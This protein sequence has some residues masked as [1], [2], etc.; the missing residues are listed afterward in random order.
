MIAV[1]AGKADG[2]ETSAECGLE[3]PP[4]T[5]LPASRGIHRPVR[6]HI[7]DARRDFDVDV[8]CATWNVEDVVNRED[9][10]FAQRLRLDQ[11]DAVRPR[12]GCRAGVAGRRPFGEQ[13]I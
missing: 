3:G 9:A 6:F 1:D 4:H 5:D 12:L 2:Y 8:R 11:V 13:A 10:W 7:G